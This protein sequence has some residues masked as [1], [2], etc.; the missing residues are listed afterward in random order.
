MNAI[1]APLAIGLAALLLVGLGVAWWEH[2]R[3]VAEMQ[4]RLEHS[5]HSR[6]VLE[7]QAGEMDARLLTLSGALASRPAAAASSGPADGDQAERAATLSTAMQ[8]MS[9]TASTATATSG[10]TSSGAG[11]A[12]GIGDERSWQ[13]TQPT[14]LKSAPPALEPHPPADYAPTQPA[15]LEYAP[16]QPAPLDMT[17]PPR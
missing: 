12:A 1:W 16:T 8:R 3:R 17:L 7:R 11:G 10:T 6:S 5:E 13:E 15:P 9:S 14:V 4:R 2:R